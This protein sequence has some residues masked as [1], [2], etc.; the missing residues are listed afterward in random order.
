MKKII[1]TVSITAAIASITTRFYM[2]QTAK[3]DKACTIT[4]SGE[5]HEYK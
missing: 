3:P 5:A 4:W 1:I 2:I